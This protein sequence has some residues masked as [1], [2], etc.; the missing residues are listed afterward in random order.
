MGQGS[1][2][3]HPLGSGPTRA[4]VTII[5]EFKALLGT[6]VA[7]RYHERRLRSANLFW[8]TAHRHPGDVNLTALCKVLPGRC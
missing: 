1:G 3:Q 5:G 4:D 7:A 2:V 6:T 8:E